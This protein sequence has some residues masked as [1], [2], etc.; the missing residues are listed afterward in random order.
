MIHRLE[1]RRLLLLA[2][3]VAPVFARAQEPTTLVPPSKAPDAAPAGPAGPARSPAPPIDKSKSYYVFFDQ[4]IDINSMQRLREQLTKL[5]EAGVSDITLVMDSA[6]GLLEPTLIT[7]SFIQALPAKI[8]THAQGFVQ[9]AAT[10]LFLAG[11]DRSADRDARFLFHPPFSSSNGVVGAQQMRER[12]QAFDAIASIMAQIYHDR[13]KLT[14][15]E[16]ERF[17]RETVIYDAQQAYASG[18]IQ[19]IA[20]LRIPGGGKAKIVLTE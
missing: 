3:L 5:V 20:D 16:I 19:T 15:S 18:V 4:V 14:D 7:Y 1:R 13:T 12:L 8:S 17:A 10:L 6:G 9:S 11:Q 2:G